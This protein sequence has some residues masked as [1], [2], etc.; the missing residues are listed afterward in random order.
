[1][2]TWWASVGLVVGIALLLWGADRFVRGAS[3]LA[4]HLHWP[5]L[6]IGTVLVGFATSF[7]EMLV[8][9]TAAWHQHA[10]LA[11]G[12]ALGSYVANT[13][14]VLGVTVLLVPLTVQPLLLRRELPVLTAV[15]GLLYL[16]LMDGYLGRLDGVIL[17]GLLTSLMFILVLFLRHKAHERGQ[18]ES[19]EQAMPNI[20]QLKSVIYLILGLGVLL[21]SSHVLILSAT[22]LAKAFGVSD[23][24][25]GLTVVAVG[26]SLPELAASVVGAL[27]G[28]HDIAIG[29]VIGSN[30]FGLLGVVAMPG[31][32]APGPFAP[33]V[34]TRDFGM[35]VLSTVVL[36]LAVWPFKMR[37]TTQ[38]TRL[39]GSALCACFLFYLLLFL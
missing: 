32:F 30:I 18:D 3:A 23:L 34:L 26:T 6:L 16:L 29:N 35:M 15:L 22:T 38:L 28:E 5:P 1:M 2:T 9:L 37:R 31:L 21:G 13:T 8:S 25:I 39:G 4:Y 20:S 19:A 10:G 27:Q 11:L 24:V 17:L 33:E 7:P 14:L 12:N 36:W